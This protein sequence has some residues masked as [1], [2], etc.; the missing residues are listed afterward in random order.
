[1]YYGIT[2]RQVGEA[3]IVGALVASLLFVLFLCIGLAHGTIR[4]PVDVLPVAG[5][6]LLIGGGLPLFI[7]IAAILGIRVVDDQVEQVLF[8]RWVLRRRPAAELA[9]A[10]YGGSLFPVVLSFRDGARMRMLGVPRHGRDPSAYL[11][12]PSSGCPWCSRACD[13]ADPKR[14]FLLPK[15]KRPGRGGT[16]TVKP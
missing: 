5:L 10:F 4:S 8:G 7:G 14:P 15:Q 12:H 9:G 1:M 13:P 6:S 16:G 11:P 2:R 3:G